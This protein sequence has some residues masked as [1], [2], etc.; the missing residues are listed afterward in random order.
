M[1]KKISVLNQSIGGVLIIL[2]IAG[3]SVYQ[4][5]QDENK[6]H[7]MTWEFA[8]KD[9]SQL[10][11]CMYLK[12]FPKGRYADQAHFICSSYPAPTTHKSATPGNLQNFELEMVKLPTGIWMGKYEVTQNQWLAVMGSNPSAYRTFDF[13]VENVSWNDVQIFIAQLNKKTGKTYR[14]PTEKEW[15]EACQAGENHE[16]CGSNDVD[17]VAWHGH[18]SKGYPHSVGQKMS[19]AWG[20]YDISGNVYEW[21]SSL[22]DNKPNW[23]V[24]RGGSWNHTP[25][26]SR[27]TVRMAFGPNL[28]YKFQGFRLVKD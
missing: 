3:W 1:R 14:L 17:E 15:L 19:N 13:P 18:N 5:Q 28:H 24:V 8:E 2:V 12:E 26:A 27:A 20:L 7:D 4:Y 10:A 11:Y 16:Y 22:Y 23:H 6:R 9:G 21:T 25:E